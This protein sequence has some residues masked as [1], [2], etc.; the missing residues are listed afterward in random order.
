MNSKVVAFAV[1]ALTVLCIVQVADVDAEDT[2][3]FDITDGTGETFHFEG[4]AEH[5]VTSG[6]ATTLTV[7]DAGAIDKIVAVDKY[8]TYEQ[9][10]D[11]RLRDLHAIDLGSF[12][13]TTNDDYIVITLVN[14]VE[15]GQMSLNDPIILTSYSDNVSLKEK[16]EGYGFTHVLM[17]ITIDT[18]D[19]LISMVS[20][21][22][23][24]ATGSVPASVADMQEKFDAVKDGVASIADGDRTKALYVWYYS[25]EYTIGNTGIMTSMLEACNADDI[26]HNPDKSESRYGDSNMIVSIL[27]DNP[28]TVIFLSHSFFS[29]GYTLDDFY[30]QMFGGDR[31]FTVVP[32]GQDWNNWCPESADGL[33]SIA[34]C[35]YPDVFGEYTGEIGGGPQGGDGGI[36]MV[37]VGI[38]I[39]IVIV[40]VAVAA[41]YF[42][43]RKP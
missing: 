16:L 40:I 3:A 43:K 6:F 39:V 28:G 36:D 31:T 9:T 15:T 7:I 20:D 24:I 22:S 2:G 10:G 35:L 30:Q 42:A 1:A 19:Q 14:L 5:I 11:E 23:R 26:G 25:G 18:Y 8:S 29:A 17:W 27:D 32:M 13:G 12:Y 41:Y 21:V 38:A 4:A 37:T 34:Q 33:M